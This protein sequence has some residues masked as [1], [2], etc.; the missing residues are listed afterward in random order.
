MWVQQMEIFIAV[1]R[2]P[3]VLYIHT[4]LYIEQWRLHRS[5]SLLLSAYKHNPAGITDDTQNN[6][7]SQTLINY[8]R[9]Y[10]T[11]SL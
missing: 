6:R 9:I 4:G 5:T 2:L 8:D 1:K 7:T 3:R 10:R 11:T